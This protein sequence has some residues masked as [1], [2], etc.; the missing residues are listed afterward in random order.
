[1][2]RSALRRLTLLLCLS[3]G[4]AAADGTLLIQLKPDGNYR[5]WHAAGKSTLNDDEVAVLAAHAEPAGSAA[6]A[7]TAGPARAFATDYG[8]VVKLDAVKGD[9]TLLIDR[10]DCGAVKLWHGEGGSVPSDDELTEL[11]MSALPGGGKRLRLGENYAKSFITRAGVVA[12]VWKA[13]RR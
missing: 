10:D 12:V 5:I 7:T 3:A 11:M 8:V 9:D 1:M 6:V 4:A 2:I 13:V